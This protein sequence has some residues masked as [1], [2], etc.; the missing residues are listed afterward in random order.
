MADTRQNRVLMLFGHNDR[1]QFTTIY[2]RQT[3]F[4]ELIESYIT[5]RNRGWIIVKRESRTTA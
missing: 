2:S 3:D 1:L 4:D 5:L